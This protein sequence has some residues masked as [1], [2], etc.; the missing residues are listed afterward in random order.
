MND[1]LNIFDEQKNNSN[2]LNS[3][4]DN[5]NTKSV[6]TTTLYA[7]VAKPIASTTSKK[8]KRIKLKPWMRVLIGVFVLVGTFALGVVAGI[9]IQAVVQSNVDSTPTH[10][11]PYITYK[12]MIYLYP[13]E[14]TR[15]S[16]RLGKSEL[17]TT[18]YP[19]YDGG[20]TVLAEPN[21]TLYDDS[22]REFYGLY[23]EG[24]GNMASVREDGFVVP[25]AD[26][27]R[28][29]EEKLAVLGLT[30]R[31]ANEFIVYWLPEL[32]DNLYN[33]VR[34]ETR[35]EIEDYMPLAVS[36]TPNSV[37][38]VIMDY[39]PLSEPIEVSEQHLETPSRTGFTVVEWGGTEIGKE[40]AH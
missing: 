20:W 40:I 14:E 5:L 39:K 24:A 17:L 34:F 2:M 19:K 10:R 31:E 27:A 36:P 30:E 13:E 12:P 38:R 25:G 28:F 7:T 18:T 32:E 23:W 11:D 4:G 33:Y 9:M 15:V 35:E 26:T 3:Q 16:V 22:G 21:G 29:L 6:E 37:V 8:S 1:D